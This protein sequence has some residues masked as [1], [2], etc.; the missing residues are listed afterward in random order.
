MTLKTPMFDFLSFS[1][2]SSSHKLTLCHHLHQLF[3]SQSKLDREVQMKQWLKL[4]KMRIMTES[5]DAKNKMEQL[6]YH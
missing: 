1:E 5:A 6:H 3:D 4:V 2:N